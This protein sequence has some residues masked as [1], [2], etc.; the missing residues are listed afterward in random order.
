MLVVFEGCDEVII[1]EVDS[2]GNPIGDEEYFKEP[3]E[4]D[5]NREDYDKTLVEGP[6]AI[7]PR[8]KVEPSRVLT[9]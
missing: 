1:C 2:E 8:L 4:G 7:E 3:G 5:R 6:V 9:R